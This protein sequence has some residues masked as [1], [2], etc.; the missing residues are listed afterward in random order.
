MATYI[1][2]V[3]YEGKV[4]ILRDLEY[5]NIRECKSELRANGYQIRVVTTED[6]FDEAC[7][8]YLAKKE[9][10]S[11]RNKVKWEL[12]KERAKEYGTSVKTFRAARKALL[13]KDKDG[14]Y[15]NIASSLEDWIEFYDEH[16]DFR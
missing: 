12:D 13:E 3:K 8:K 4:Q 1:A 14:N 7:E 15:V 11:I 2:S 5:N 10:K 9:D 6:K 16:K